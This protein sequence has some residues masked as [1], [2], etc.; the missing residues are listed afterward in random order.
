MTLHALIFDC[1]G[2]LADTERDG[3]LPAFN[4]AFAHFELPVKWSVQE[5][6][7]LLAIGG[8]KERMSTL[9]D[10]PLREAKF[11]LPPELRLSSL[12]RWH[13]F[14]TDEY[15]KLIES[16]AVPGR[17]GV[18]RLVR[19]ASD[20]GWLLAVASTSAHAS[21]RAVLVHAVGEKLASL[22]RVF[23]GDDV[24]V[25]KPAPDIYSLALSE[26]GTE[27][28]RTMVIEDSGI[29]CRAAL[30]AGLR[31]I[32]TVSTYTGSDDFTGASLVVSNLDEGSVSLSTIKALMTETD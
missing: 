24:A 20:A 1:D 22:F 3:H 17:P 32:V 8:G 26:L 2:V 7:P 5:Y 9:F 18:R 15:I 29:G 31:V 16:G 10:G 19:E 25:K 27:P 14:K 30:A 11:S 21:V 23:A 13:R 12:K 4:S 28:S 6:G